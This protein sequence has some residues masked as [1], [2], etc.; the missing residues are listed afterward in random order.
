MDSELAFYDRLYQRFPVN[1]L[2]GYLKET[3][4]RKELISLHIS[5]FIEVLCDIEGTNNFYTKNVIKVLIDNIGL[6]N[7]TVEPQDNTLQI[8]ANND[9]YLSDW[10]YEK[11][12]ELLDIQQ[13][14]PTTK[15]VIQYRINNQIKIKIEESPYLISAAGTTGFRT[16]EAAVYLTKYLIDLG[17]PPET[18]MENTLELGSGT[19]MVSIGLVK[20]YK[21]QITTL[22]I[23]DGDSQ[24]LEGQLS[25]NVMLNGIDSSDSVKLQKLRWNEDHI[26]DN[27]DLIVAADV[28]YDSSV[29]PSLCHCILDCFKSSNKCSTVCYLAATRRNQETIAVFE[30]HCSDL[31]LT[32]KLAA[33]TD[34][35]VNSCK[36]VE[37]ILFKPLIAPINIYKITYSANI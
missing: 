35:D 8:I 1:Q 23:T 36:I 19:G 15:D 16:W 20:K 5:K 26:P 13:P 3:I 9:I 7:E 17:F 29:I 28:T 33:C 31:G 18:V 32:V 34:S 4:S 37:D 2:A 14:T 11:Y 10:L 24:L 6:F 21:D 12:I 30:Q 27:L 25:R 22:Y